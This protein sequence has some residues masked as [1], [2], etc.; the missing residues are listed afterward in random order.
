MSEEIVNAAVER[1][2]EAYK[3]PKACEYCGSTTGCLR[4]KGWPCTRE[5]ADAIARRGGYGKPGDPRSYW[6]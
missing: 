5:E 6:D 1:I 2:V 4:D 3:P